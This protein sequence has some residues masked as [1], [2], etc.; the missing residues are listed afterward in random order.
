MKPFNYVKTNELTHL[1][2]KLPTSYLLTDSMF[3]SEF[4]L[5]NS[6]GYH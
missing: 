3:K 5:N 2:I 4:T 6:Q 1:E